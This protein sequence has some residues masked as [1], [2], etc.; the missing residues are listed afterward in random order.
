[1]S[2]KSVSSLYK[3]SPSNPAISFGAAAESTAWLVRRG[4]L[5]CHYSYYTQWYGWWILT[6]QSRW[7]PRSELGASAHAN[8]DPRHG[9][10]SAPALV[11]PFFLNRWSVLALGFVLMLSVSFTSWIN[12]LTVGTVLGL[13][14]CN[15]FVVQSLSK[16]P[17]SPCNCNCNFTWA[18]TF[19]CYTL[20]QLWQT[21]RKAAFPTLHPPL[22]GNDQI[23]N[24]YQCI[25][26]HQKTLTSDRYTTTRSSSHREWVFT[27]VHRC[28][29]PNRCIYI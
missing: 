5:Q 7:R 11:N 25:C 22:S 20:T 12:L 18:K 2:W 26:I 17:S 10:G 27:Q 19:N 24:I 4:G 29:M 1:M 16:W 28:R 8:L 23:A 13:I 3:L 6:G 21:K 14:C 9:N 15:K